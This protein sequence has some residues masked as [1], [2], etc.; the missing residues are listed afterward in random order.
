MQQ[1]GPGLMASP[2]PEFNDPLM[3]MPRRDPM[4]SLASFAPSSTNPLA[5]MASMGSSNKMETGPA[6]GTAGMSPD[7]ASLQ[8]QLDESR[9]QARTWKHEAEKNRLMALS[10]AQRLRDIRE[11]EKLVTDAGIAEGTIQHLRLQ[12]SKAASQRATAERQIQDNSQVIAE[13]SLK[14]EGL[15]L[16]ASRF[17]STKQR[18]ETAIAEKQ[19]EL[20]QARAELTRLQGGLRSAIENEEEVAA[21]QSFETEESAAKKE[22]RIMLLQEQCLRLQKSVLHFKSQNES[23]GKQVEELS[24]KVSTLYRTMDL[25]ED[26]HQKDLEAQ[27]RP[28]P[29]HRPPPDPG[30]PLHDDLLA[31]QANSQ[32]QG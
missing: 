29:W 9:R 26:R 25:Q 24:V 22:A 23:A 6:G 15:E 10:A 31:A 1:S 8:A 4:A 32:G 5:S 3:S 20:S 28:R 14:V 13:L 12:L 27:G 16:E 18:L 21:M 11:K 30:D 2:L 7:A 19:R 17:N